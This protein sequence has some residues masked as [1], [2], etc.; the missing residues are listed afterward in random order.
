[1][2][3]R[4][5]PEFQI[6]QAE[7]DY[8]KSATPQARDFMFG[9]LFDSVL[10]AAGNPNIP[11]SDVVKDPSGRSTLKAHLLGMKWV[12]RQTKKPDLVIG[13]T[14]IVLE[15]GE[16]DLGWKIIL[17]PDLAMLITKSDSPVSSTIG[18]GTLEAWEVDNINLETAARSR[19]F[20]VGGNRSAVE[21]VAQH[22]KGR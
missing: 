5:I 13:D 12:L 3:E 15:R 11:F 17:G 21:A 14:G 9:Q 2:A 8:L 4:G 19:R 7:F 16:I 20:L 18:D 22:V 6:N 10:G 1:M